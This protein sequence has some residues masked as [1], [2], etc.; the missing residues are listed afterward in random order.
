[1][2][3][4]NKILLIGRLT[5]DPELRYVPNGGPAV[6]NFTLAVGRPFKNQNNERETDFIDIVV[7]RKLAENCKQYLSKGKMVMV[8]GRLQIRSYEA[9]DGA[10]RKIT[11]IVAD[12]IQFLDRF[13]SSSPRAAAG[14]GD[15]PPP[16]MVDE[17]PPIEPISGFGSED[18]DQIPF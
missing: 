5:R 11:E 18:D 12:N 17:L 16:D 6:A 13:A 10:K 7:W 9:S 2:A 3:T 4:L 14:P 15:P 1:M 8:E